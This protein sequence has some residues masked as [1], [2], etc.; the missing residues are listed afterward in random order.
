MNTNDCYLLVDA[1]R[2]RLQNLNCAIDVHQYWER[3]VGTRGE[4]KVPILPAVAARSD[5]R[6]V[7]EDSDDDSDGEGLPSDEDSDVEA[8]DEKWKWCI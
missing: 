2:C 1:M 6:L 5:Q 8:L 3:C 4:A 7:K